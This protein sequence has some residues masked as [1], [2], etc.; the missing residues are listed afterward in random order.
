MPLALSPRIEA[1]NLLIALVL[2][3]CDCDRVYLG[4]DGCIFSDL[5]RTFKTC[6]DDALVKEVAST[7]RLLSANDSPLRENILNHKRLYFKLK[8]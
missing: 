6:T 7:A 8:I 1:E 3:S 5:M 4:M 2:N